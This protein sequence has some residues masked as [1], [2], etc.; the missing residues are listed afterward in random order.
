[1]R[2][3]R[4]VTEVVDTA[5]EAL[6]WRRSRDSGGDE[7]GITAAVAVAVTATAV[8]TAALA[9]MAVGL[10]VVRDTSCSS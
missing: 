3:G 8:A 2:E 1:M 6:R 7:E 5:E 9:P 10:R 4:R